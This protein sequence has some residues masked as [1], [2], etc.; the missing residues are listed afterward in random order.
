MSTP[1]LSQSASSP[2][3]RLPVT[4]SAGWPG[5]PPSSR[6]DGAHGMAIRPPPQHPGTTRGTGIARSRF[7]RLGESRPPTVDGR[8]HPCAAVRMPNR[9]PQLAAFGV[10]H[11]TGCVHAK[12]IYPQRLQAAAS[13]P[14]AGKRARPRPRER[15]FKVAVGLARSDAEGRPELVPSATAPASARWRP[16]PSGH[17]GRQRP[18]NRTVGNAAWPGSRTE[19]RQSWSISIQCTRRQLRSRTVRPVPSSPPRSPPVGPDRQ[20]SLRSDR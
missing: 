13:F 2:G 3:R 19:T 12:E 17:A 10:G 18:S 5:R 1:R 15:G 11:E 7:G 4:G 6:T 8:A 16:W 20:A 9:R 14:S